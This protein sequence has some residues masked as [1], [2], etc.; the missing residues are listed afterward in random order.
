MSFGII[1][2]QKGNGG[3]GNLAAFRFT[4]PG[5]NES[6]ICDEHAPQMR[7]VASAMG[8]NCQLIPLTS[9]DHAGPEGMKSVEEQRETR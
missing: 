8:F 9:A 1:C 3:C 4:W 2:R 7:G 5:S 6:F